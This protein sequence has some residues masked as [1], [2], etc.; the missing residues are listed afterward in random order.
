MFIGEYSHNLDA[1][2]RLAVPVKFRD[3]LGRS[4]VIT[5]GLDRC[6]FLYSKKAW[7]EIAFKLGKMPIGE[8]GTRSFVRLMLAGA[9]EVK[10]DGLGRILIP[11]Y[12][13]DYAVLGKNAVI[14]GLFNR[15]EIWEE[16]Q[17]KAYKEKAEKDTEKVAE[18]LGELGAY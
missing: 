12:L 13:K 5:R 6:L 2:N 4:A 8:G 9:S 10:L 14:N 18:K 11:E 1:K 15:L 16:K 17:W 3:E 7:E